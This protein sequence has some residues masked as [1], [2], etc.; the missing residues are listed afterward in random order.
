MFGWCR[1]CV[2]PTA[3][4]MVDFATVVEYPRD[5]AS[6]HPV[7]RWCAI[8]AS[9][10]MLGVAAQLQEQWC[11]VCRS[12]NAGLQIPNLKLLIVMPLSRG[13]A[14]GLFPPN[15]V[16]QTAGR[17]ASHQWHSIPPVNRL[18]RSN[19]KQ[20]ISIANSMM[21]LLTPVILTDPQKKFWEKWIQIQHIQSPIINHGIFCWS[22]FAWLA[23]GHQV[24]TM[25]VLH[26]SNLLIA[27]RP[28]IFP[29]NC[30][31]KKH[32]TSGMLIWKAPASINH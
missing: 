22:G 1:Y 2:A 4:T 31:H 18:L 14:A 12:D 17:C 16:I 10:P 26:N 11:A 23:F 8:S 24:V 30:W 32:K 25:V 19:R 9:R 7:A 20:S 21:R 27:H 29:W 28:C 5:N 13:H 3:L 6:Q 15:F